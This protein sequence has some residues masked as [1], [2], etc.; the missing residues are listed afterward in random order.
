MRRAVVTSAATVSGV[1][2]L[3]SLKPQ[4]AQT[5]GGA[6]IST[7]S[8]G[9]GA[10]GAGSASGNGASGSGSTGPTTSTGSTGS[11][12]ASSSAA[13]S[14]TGDAVDTRYGP[15]QVKITVSNKK[16]SDVSVLQ[17][18]SDNSRSQEINSYALP[19]LNQEAMSAQ[20]AQVD[21]VSGASYTSEG[22]VQSLQSA[23]DK[24]GL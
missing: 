1:I 2:L 14:V 23:I 13:R 7:A 18:P 16:I 8:G 10:S 3:L 9:R 17:Y 15:V 21:A 5:S 20:S 24:A 6:P 4:A 11:G 22:Y 19:I 12:S